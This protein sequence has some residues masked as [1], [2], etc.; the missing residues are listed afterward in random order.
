MPRKKPLKGVIYALCVIIFAVSMIAYPQEVFEASQRGLDAWWNIVFPALLPFF[1]VSHLM[2]SFGIV[3]FLGVL[4]EPL[5]KPIF[6]VPGNGAFVMAMGYTS[7][8]PIGSLLTVDLRK[9]NLCTRIEG[10]RLISFTNNASPLFMFGAVSI[11]MFNNPRLGIILASAHY[12]ANLSIG[13]LLRFYGYNDPEKLDRNISTKKIVRRSI[14]AMLAVQQKN[15]KPLG[16][17]LGTAIKKSMA[18]LSSIGGFIILFSVILQVLIQLGVIPLISILLAKVLTSLGLDAQLSTSLSAGL[19]EVTLGSKLASEIHVPLYQQL[20]AVS[21]VMGW[22]GLSVHAQVASIISDTDLR[23]WPFV[24]SRFGQGLLA[25]IYFV[26]FFGP[27]TPVFN[28]V[29]QIDYIAAQNP[30]WIT[31]LIQLATF[32]TIMFGAAVL[33]L[34]LAIWQNTFGFRVR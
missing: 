4:L 20:I 7:G 5:M 26:I 3:H 32:I 25:T 1:I 31:I 13:L 11:G 34:L 18:T 6:N 8:F 23:L 28:Q 24:L 14:Q 30:L 9:N 19:F 10:E 2:M 22:S 12:C 15:E 21:M 33:S 27:A 16:E 17:L 29:G